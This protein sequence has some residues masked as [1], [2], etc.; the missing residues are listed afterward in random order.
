MYQRNDDDEYE[1]RDH[2]RWSNIKKSN[3]KM[4]FFMFIVF[5]GTKDRETRSLVLIFSKFWQNKVIALNETTVIKVALP[6]QIGQAGTHR[7]IES[8]EFQKTLTSQTF[9]FDC[10]SNHSRAPISTGKLIIKDSINLD[11]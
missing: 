6:R 8:V 4:T 11:F 3:M 5:I 1:K 2:K 10:F 9:Y 7:Q